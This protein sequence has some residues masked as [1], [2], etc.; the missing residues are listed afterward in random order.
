MVVHFSKS[1]AYAKGLSKKLRQHIFMK[2]YYDSVGFVP[3][4][5]PVSHPE[6]TFYKSFILMKNAVS[7][8]SDLNSSEDSVGIIHKSLG[9]TRAPQKRLSTPS[10]NTRSGH[11]GTGTRPHRNVKLSSVPTS[12]NPS[13]SVMSNQQPLT[14]SASPYQ[15]KESSENWKAHQHLH[16]GSIVMVQHP[17]KHKNPVWA[18][19]VAIG[20]HGI[21]CMDHDGEKHMIRWNHIQDVQPV[22]SSGDLDGHDRDARTELARLGMPVS[23]VSLNS[24]EVIEAMDYLRNAKIPLVNDARLDDE[25]VDE[26]YKEMA[27][28]HLPVDPVDMTK[29]RQPKKE[30]PEYLS[31]LAADVQG[32]GE[33]INVELLAKLS[34]KD[35]L[36]VLSHYFNKERD[37]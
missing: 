18:R 17:F 5:P 27:E 7:S 1:N 21:T 33:N 22:I 24:A 29:M 9:G 36:E 23:A 35:I 13:P 28:M 2:K 19:I 37:A 32:K 10:S 25:E 31:K 11:V 26:A 4:E 14:F 3:E 6:E 30:L 20:D 15:V 34:K 16:V 8:L 12:S